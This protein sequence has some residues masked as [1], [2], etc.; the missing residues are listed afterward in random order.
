[1][2]N[3]NAELPREGAL[4]MILESDDVQAIATASATW[5]Y[6]GGGGVTDYFQMRGWGTVSLAFVYWTVTGSPDPTGASAPEVVTDVIL[7][8]E[9][10][11]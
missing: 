9:W 5:T 10:S 6:G 7:I 1:M 3:Y 2:A 4:D 11:A 8:S